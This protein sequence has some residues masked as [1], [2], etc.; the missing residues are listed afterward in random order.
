MGRSS[1]SSARSTTGL[2]CGVQNPPLEHH[3]AAAGIRTN[4]QMVSVFTYVACQM[5]STVEAMPWLYARMG[6]TIIIPVSA[7]R[8]MRRVG[9][10]TNV[11][12]ASASIENLWTILLLPVTG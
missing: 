4:L 12:P 9:S 6:L 1:T 10:T 8:D 3:R 5:T 7:L 2:L 11:Y